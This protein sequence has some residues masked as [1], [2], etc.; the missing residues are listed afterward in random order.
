[1]SDDCPGTSGGL[2]DRILLGLIAI[3]SI[4]AL[5][6]F[7]NSRPGGGHGLLK[8]QIGIGVFLIF[9]LGAGICLYLFTDAER[10][11]VFALIL[12]MMILVSWSLAGIAFF[13]DRYHVPVLTTIVIMMILPRLFGWVDSKEEHYISTA[14][15]QT[16][17]NVTDPKTGLTSFN[18]PTPGKIVAAM[19]GASDDPLIIVTATGGGLHASAW[20]ATIMSKLENEFRNPPEGKPW[21]PF[22]RHIL[23]ASTVSGGSVGLLSYL[24]EIQFDPSD[25]DFN[26][27]R[28][29]NAAGCSSLE[30]VGWGLVYY[31]LPKAFLPVIPYFVS[32]SSGENDLA[33][34]PL[35]KDRTWALRKGFARNLHDVYC[36]T[37]LQQ[38]EKGK[39]LDY[40]FANVKMKEEIEKDVQGLTLENLLANGQDGKIPAFTMNTTT[41][42]G[43][44]RFLLS[45]YRVPHQRLGSIES[46]TAESFLDL[47]GDTSKTD[48][49]TDLPLA[50]AAQLSATF[51]YVSSAARIPASIA[52]KGLH[53]VD[54]GYYDNDGTASAIEFLRSALDAPEVKSLKK[55]LRIILVEIRNSPDAPDTPPATQQPSTLLDQIEA[56]LLGF[57]NSGHGS[58]TERD[59]VGLDMLV[60]SFPQELQLQRFVF[61]DKDSEHTVHTDPLNWSLT[62]KQR[63]EVQSSAQKSYAKESQDAAAKGN[64]VP[65]GY[66]EVKMWFHDFETKWASA[67]SK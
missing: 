36:E 2:V 48:H 15:G 50:S 62:P 47:Y 5:W 45:N 6:V 59:R 29:V 44:A 9:F 40:L 22:H 14:S 67:R 26:E 55:P 66:E 65:R 28:V 16:T 31:D 1:V 51:P 4:V 38:D 3:P 13:V 33:G 18:V 23:L 57:W 42:E 24:R 12:I 60:K 19:S 20:T 63:D 10:F 8:W 30:A 53:F 49:L 34:S 52:C 21:K 46:Y 27:S 64:K 17:L 56:P 37:G 35:L 7:W 32:P 54:G 58:N 11:P 61:D 41:V 39:K 43:G 25:Q